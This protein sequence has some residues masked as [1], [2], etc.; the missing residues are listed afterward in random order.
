MRQIASPKFRKQYKKLPLKVQKKFQKQVKLLLQDYRYPS[1]QSKRM[2][3]EEIFE[4]RIDYHYRFT[5]KIKGEK[6]F[7]FSIG[8]HDEGLGKK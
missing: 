1:L 5:Y 8:P 6:I 3:D 7:F 2:R 4:A